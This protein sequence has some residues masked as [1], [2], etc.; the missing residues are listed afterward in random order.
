MW[1]SNV[2]I[3]TL[4]WF[5]VSIN[6][7][8]FP[9]SWDTVP[10]FT[11]F[12]THSAD[13][14]TD[15]EAK[16]VAATY[17]LVSVAK[18]LGPSKTNITAES[19][20]YQIASLIRKYAGPNETK[21]IFSFA[22]DSPYCSCYETCKSVCNNQSMWFRD[23]SG[24][25]LYAG[26]KPYY[27]YTQKYVRDW[28]VNA[29][30]SILKTGLSKNLQ[31]NGVFVDGLVKNFT[32]KGSYNVSLI[33]NNEWQNAA[34]ATMDS[35]RNAFKSISDDL[36]VIGNGISTYSFSFPP[37]NYGLEALPHVD[38]LMHGHFGSFEEVLK[39]ENG[40][41]NP[42]DII[43]AFNFSRDI[44]NGV[45]GANKCILFKAW[46]GPE[47]SPTNSL[48]PTWPTD[49]DVTPNT[50]EGI[51]KAA[52]EK[53]SFPLASFLCG[54]VYE[55]MY[56]GYAWFWN[57]DQGWVTC[58]DDPSS[59]DAPVNWY[60]EFTNKLGRP[61]SDPI[62]TDIYKCNRTFEYAEVYVDVN[63]NTSAVIT[64]K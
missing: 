24:N 6:G 23:D 52:V 7:N 21:I 44:A 16:F 15:S 29:T 48:G 12:G 46:I 35:L 38:G 42:D 26:S 56:F 58:P 13:L 1:A 20:F 11:N 40:K 61:L 30:I 9:W 53:L 62:M 5:I 50:R 18:C 34:F 3:F 32:Q 25:I 41:I 37:N 10:L 31:I 2:M 51:Q 28:W 36:F 45:Y 54:M 4:S 63:D 27:D 55:Y 59:C 47:G 33:R 17:P 43:I 19:G 60:K 22:G 57:I 39:N 49:Y 14:I 8:K 64:W